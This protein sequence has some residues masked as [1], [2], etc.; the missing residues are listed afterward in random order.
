MLRS[1]DGEICMDI[2][3]AC[4]EAFTGQIIQRFHILAPESHTPRVTIDRVTV[5]RET[6]RFPPAE[7]SFAFEKDETARFLAARRF[8]RSHDLPRFVFIKVP[9]EVKPFYVDFDS[10]IYVDILSKMIR[11]TKEK[12]AADALVSVTEMHPRADETWLPD[13]EGQ[14]YTS[15][16]RF[17]CV[18]PLS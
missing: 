4:A 15:E 12:G 9:V 7:L 17:V 10:P 6:W 18:D 14:H 5:C 3:E 16:L 1:R 13:A 11:R 8:A 2:V